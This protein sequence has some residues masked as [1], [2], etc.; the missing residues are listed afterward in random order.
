MQQSQDFKD[1]Y[2]G[3]LKDIEDLFH[4]QFL[5]E[6]IHPSVLQFSPEQVVDFIINFGTY[7]SRAHQTTQQEK[8]WGG[9]EAK[10]VKLADCIKNLPI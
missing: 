6:E 1:K 8:I 2:G 9:I 3:I 5:S 4:E 7:L 10:L